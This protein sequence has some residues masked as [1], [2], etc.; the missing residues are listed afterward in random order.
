M[1]KIALAILI[2]AVV[3]GATYGGV[4]FAGK[5][6]PASYMDWVSS[7]TDETIL[8]S[9]QYDKGAH[10][11]LTILA[12][13]IDAGEKILVQMNWGHL[14]TYAGDWSGWTSEY[15]E[16]TADGLYEYQFDAGSC[17]ILT[18]DV[19]NVVGLAYAMTITSR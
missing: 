13:D 18:Q 11:S 4:V 6:A 10:F 19:A 15:E 3:I 17:Q 7:N 1:K 16:I 5:P 2:L 9:G 12:T 8:T 14:P